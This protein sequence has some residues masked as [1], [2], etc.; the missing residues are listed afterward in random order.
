MG[1]LLIR[2]I[3]FIFQSLGVWS[4]D[5]IPRGTRF[6]PLVGE[7]YSREPYVSTEAERISIWKVNNIFCFI[8]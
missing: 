7:V 4:L 8:V 3:F 5:Y 6:G 2:L 1:I